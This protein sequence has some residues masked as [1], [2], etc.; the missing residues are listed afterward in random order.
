MCAHLHYVVA[1]S[2]QARDTPKVDEAGCDLDE[3]SADENMRVLAVV[4]AYSWLGSYH[5]RLASILPLAAAV[6]MVFQASVA[7]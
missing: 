7:G 3:E 5:C 4:P 2:E 1:A 6:L